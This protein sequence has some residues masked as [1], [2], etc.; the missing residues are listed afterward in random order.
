M[1]GA[2]GLEFTHVAL[3]GVDDATIPGAPRR[4]AAE[5]E[6]NTVASERRLLYVAMTRARDGLVIAHTAGK[7]SRFLGE[8]P[9]GMGSAEQKGLLRWVGEA[10]S[11]NVCS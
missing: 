4:H 11:W 7:G 3:L 10:M 6:T 5:P 9:E 1:H 2:K 8:L